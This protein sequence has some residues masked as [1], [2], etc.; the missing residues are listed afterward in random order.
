MNEFYK[1]V[2]DDQ[3]KHFRMMINTEMTLGINMSCSKNV[4]EWNYAL[5]DEGGYEGVKLENEKFI[6]KN[7]TLDVTKNFHEFIR[8]IKCHPKYRLR[9]IHKLDDKIRTVWNKA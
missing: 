7:K 3:E 8:L 6:L 5:W 1:V 4:W 2:S 9:M